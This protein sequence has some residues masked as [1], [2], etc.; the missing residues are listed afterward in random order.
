MGCNSIQTPCHY[1]N[2]PV[3]VHIYIYIYIYIYTYTNRDIPG[4]GNGLNHMCII[5]CLNDHKISPPSEFW[6]SLQ[7]VTQ[8]VMQL[9]ADSY[10]PNSTS[11]RKWNLSW[12]NFDIL[13]ITMYLPSYC[14]YV[15][16]FQLKIYSPCWLLTP[17]TRHLAWCNG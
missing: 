7:L 13:L 16:Y 12:K 4:P 17:L 10:L 2:K 9:S 1:W 3:C 14:S 6:S 11:W 8:L 15:S 5:E